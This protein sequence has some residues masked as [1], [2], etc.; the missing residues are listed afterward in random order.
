MVRIDRDPD[1]APHPERATRRSKHDAVLSVLDTTTR[2]EIGAVTSAGRLLRFS[3][4]DVP[5][6]PSSSVQL[7]A[8]VRMSDYLPHLAKDERVLA[9]VAL[10]DERP[11]ALGTL[12]GVVKRVAPGELPNR[13]DIELIALKP[14]DAV[15]GAA[16]SAEED[17]LVF[18]T[19]EAQLLRFSASAVRPQGRTA[20]GMVGVKLAETDDVVHFAVVAAEDRDGA[21]VATVAVDSWALSGTDTGSA[22]VS[23]FSEFPAKGRATG[24]VRAHRFLKGET[25]LGVAW[26]G[27]GP[28]HAL[29]A[30]GSAAALPDSG[31]KRDGSGVALAAPIAT[32][33]AAPE[34]F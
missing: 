28:A 12:Q 31:M 13:P 30:D 23:S 20:A 7:G 24:G 14:K 11:I 21:V 34:L 9:L 22:K 8:G 18:V 2:A 25:A 4:V 19:G 15:V 1:A 29:E 17:E 16:A 27:P 6:V 5:A 3:P 33:G 10:D 32:L 26:V